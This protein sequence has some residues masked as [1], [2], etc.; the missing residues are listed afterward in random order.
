MFP[1]DCTA[2]CSVCEALSLPE[3]HSCWPLASR[4]HTQ[5][6]ELAGQPLEQDNPAS[7]NSVM[8]FSM[9]IISL[10][11]II[12][13]TLQSASVP[14]RHYL[15]HKNAHGSQASRLCAL[16][17]FWKEIYVPPVWMLLLPSTKSL[18]EEK[19]KR[20]KEETSPF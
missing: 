18:T 16:P 5:I 3:G 9:L 15:S 1:P 6:M 19:T 2:V 14:N 17:I 7:M 4:Q 12:M 8:V 10:S 20:K 13:H 11:G